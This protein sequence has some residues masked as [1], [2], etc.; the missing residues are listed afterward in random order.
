[1]VFHVHFP[2]T[3][4]LRELLRH[5]LRTQFAPGH[6][7]EGL[8]IGIIRVRLSRRAQ[9]VSEQRLYRQQFLSVCKG[10]EDKQKP[11]RAHVETINKRSMFHSL[12]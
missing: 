12:A 11:D 10:K 1:R 8:R 9:T 5:S 6:A 2:H 3:F 4:S 7:P